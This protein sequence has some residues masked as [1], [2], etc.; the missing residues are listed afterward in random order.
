MPLVIV[1]LGGSTST[2]PAGPEESETKTPVGGAGAFRMTLPFT[3]CVIPIVVESRV[4]VITG[5]VTF[6]VAVP[7]AKPE[8]VAVIVVLPT[9]T[10][11]T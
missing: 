11:V 4:T 9:A 7:K 10:G 5:F 3:V 6:T 2:N 8:A 1:K